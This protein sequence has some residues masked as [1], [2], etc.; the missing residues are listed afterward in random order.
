ML[1]A[2]VFMRLFRIRSNKDDI[3]AKAQTLYSDF[4][5]RGY[6]NKWL[7]TALHKISTLL[8][9]TNLSPQN[10]MFFFC[11]NL[12]LVPLSPE[13]KKVINNH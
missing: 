8:D 1:L 3:K 13:I 5:Y 9:D 12:L 6:P 4:R 2:V 11:F 7:N 10:K